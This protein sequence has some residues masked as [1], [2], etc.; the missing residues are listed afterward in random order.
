M[1][2]KEVSQEAKRLI[3]QSDYIPTFICGHKMW[4]SERMRFMD[5]SGLNEVP[6]EGDCTQE[7]VRSFI[8]SG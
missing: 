1:I 6:L 3:Y 4:M 8:I 2:K 5:T 7:R